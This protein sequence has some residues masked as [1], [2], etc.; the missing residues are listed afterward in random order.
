V[1]VDGGYRDR[2]LYW[3]TQR[4]RFVLEAVLRSD[5]AQGVELLPRRGVVERTVAWLDRDRRLSK[6]DEVLTHS[7]EAFIHIAMINLMLGQLAK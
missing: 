3:V 7:S 6:D 4:S 1:W 5:D 2:L